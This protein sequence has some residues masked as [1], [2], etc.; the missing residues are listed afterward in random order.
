VLKKFVLNLG[1]FFDY[2]TALGFPGYYR[3]DGAFFNGIA[4][5]GLN[6]YDLFT[7]RKGKTQ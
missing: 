5:Y 3:G 1:F 6:R 4:R 2:N 7:I